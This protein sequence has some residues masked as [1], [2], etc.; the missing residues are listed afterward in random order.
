[1]LLKI[2]EKESIVEENSMEIETNWLRS[3]WKEKRYNNNFN[4]GGMLKF[5]SVPS[6][7][8]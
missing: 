1:M 4:K 3:A 8:N 2:V 5:E 7:S 6:N